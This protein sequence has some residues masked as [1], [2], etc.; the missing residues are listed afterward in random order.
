MLHDSELKA[1][2]FIE[3][4]KRLNVILKEKMAHEAQTA[5]LIPEIE[6]LNNT[7]KVKIQESEEWH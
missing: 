6:R 3:E 5:Q 1:E 4:I 2:K 7:L